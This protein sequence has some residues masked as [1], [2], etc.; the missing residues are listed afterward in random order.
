M[1]T[2]GVSG[3]VVA[4]VMAKTNADMEAAAIERLAPSPE[5]HVLE[6]GFGPGVG[7]EMLGQRLTAGRVA[8]A[9]PGSAML[10]VATR[11]NEKAVE[12]GRVELVL[13]YAND[14]PWPDASFNGVLAVNCAQVF[15]PMEDSYREISRVMMPGA[16]F[17]SLTHDWAVLRH[18]ESVSRWLADVRSACASCGLAQM[19][20]WSGEARSGGTVGFTAI[21]PPAG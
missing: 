1:K 15:E 5:H 6:I 9:D 12:T 18:S 20:D 14:L 21:K 17:V 7:I 2:D 16:R 3:R 4:F 19:E 8:G 11:R 10:E 13:A